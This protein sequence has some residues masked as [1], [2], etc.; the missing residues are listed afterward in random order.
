[1]TVRLTS[2]IHRCR[3]IPRANNLVRYDHDD[4]HHRHRTAAPAPIDVDLLFLVNQA[5][6]ALTAEMTSAL[7]DIAI[8]PREFCVL[9]HALKGELTQIKLAELSALDKTTMVVALDKLEKARP[10]RTS[11]V[12]YR[13]PVR[14]PE[15][16]I[17]W[18][19]W[20]GPWTGTYV[21]AM[22]GSLC[23]PF[24][25]RWLGKVPADRVS[26]EMVHIVDLL[27]T[28]A[29]IG[30]RRSN[31]PRHRRDRFPAWQTGE[32]GARAVSGFSSHRQQRPRPLRDEMAQLQNAWQERQY[33][34]LQKLVVPHL[35]DLYDN[36]QER[37]EETTGE[38]AAAT[39]AWV[40]QAMF[41]YLSAFRASLN[42]YP[43]IAPDTP[44]PM[45]RR[46]IDE[47]LAGAARSRVHKQ[48][49]RKWRPR[50]KR[51]DAD[52]G[53]SQPARRVKG[54]Q[55]ALRRRSQRS[56]PRPNP[57]QPRRTRL[58]TPMG[59]RQAQASRCPP[60]IGR[61]LRSRTA[62]ISSRR[63]RGSGMT[64]RGPERSGSL[65][66]SQRESLAAAR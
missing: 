32:V 29:K 49:R 12:A 27:P 39:H 55:P 14:G 19:G 45:R 16:T 35:I 8:T 64:R 47:W 40:A 52:R 36:Q 65:R 44:D 11:T 62:T 34:P 5:A 6:F 66:F 15:E 37:P 26:D 17:P 57:Q 1:M 13:P 46:R 51:Q 3:M 31:R 7:T 24:I 53:H 59:R 42:T 9:S 10:G 63:A 25:A 20:A 38:S 48:S 41:G 58:R 56:S 28:F 61:H 60:T 33:D 54:A 22:E 4:Q 50:T 18:R 30:A 21:T 43:P 2:E 23:V